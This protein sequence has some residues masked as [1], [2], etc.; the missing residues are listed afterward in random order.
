[1]TRRA[2]PFLAFAF[3][4]AGTC[5]LAAGNAADNDWAIYGGTSDGTRYSSL[6]QITRDN[7]GQLAE[8]W[9]F[10]MEDG[11]DPQTHPLAVDGVVYAYTPSLQ[12]IA[13]DGATGKQIWKF[14]SG[15]PGRGAQ[16]GLTWW[17]DG[18][19]KRLF[20][21]VM[22]YLYVLDPATG[23]PL[24]DFGDNGRIDLRQNMSRD[25]A[26]LYV[27]LTTPGV[28]Y[29][30]MIITGFRTA[31]SAP[32]APGDI[33][34]FDVRSG[35]LRWSFRTIPR[36]GDEGHDTW[37]PDAWKSA[38]GANNWTG[39]V[40]DQKRGIV[41]A[42][43][44]SAVDDFYGAD[45]LGNNL[46]A[47][48]LL[49]LDANTGKRLWHFQGV[50]HDIND[51]DF[52][53]PPVL[54]TL[55]HNGKPVDAV[56]QPSKQGYLFVL[57]RVTG[58]PLF[59]IQE[60]S[61]PASDVPGEKASATQPAAAVPAPVARQHLSEDI[62]TTRT[63]EAHAWALNQFRS[64]RNEGPFAP[65]RLGQQT[66][67]FPGFDGGAGWGGSAADPKRGI[68]YVNANDVAWT[69]GL[70]E[71]A[72]AKGLGAATYQS[73][74]AVCHGAER[75]GSPPAFPSLIDIRGKMTPSQITEVIHTGRGRMPAFGNLQGEALQALVDFL[76]TGKDEGG[77]RR[78]IT[79]DTK[80]RYRFTGYRKFLDPEGYPAVAPPWGT[81]NAIDLNTGK[82]LWKIPFGEYPELKAK[83]MTNTGTEN[84]GGPILTASNLLFIGATLFDKKMHAFDAA[85]G[86]LL[87]QATLPFA[88]NAT[89]ITYM[90][91]GRQFVLIQ[92]DN[93]RDKKAP[94]GSAYVAFA[95]PR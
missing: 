3:V 92:T 81:L 6:T 37:P 24:P 79:G 59:P 72:I 58:K 65:M 14:D 89:P 80:A 54:L 82:Y 10:R 71:P 91:D 48:S 53:S 64:F 77:D 76:M 21:S 43:T 62:L 73:N 7:I 1:M 29:K 13:L 94:Q 41:Y 95:L 70:A 75:A 52:P 42:P 16:R 32:A 5:A 9:S 78:E 67:S 61:T 4:A 90:A 45:R 47:N 46:F 33:R 55:R 87:W 17:S 36:P 34:A 35:R 69:G 12:V 22:H 60:V 57:D 8:V 68:I 40:V 85:T 23:K 18:R 38:G 86:K 20:A 11:G 19:E 84:Y 31:E 2:L 28:I 15:M 74:C 25:S 51:R 30:D 83:G 50:H 88:G 93:A 63:P 56:A 66:I 44:G 49:A 27:S 39:M 26:N